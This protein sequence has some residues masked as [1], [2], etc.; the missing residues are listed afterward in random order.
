MVLALDHSDAPPPGQQEFAFETP[1]YQ[2]HCS[3]PL[4]I[5]EGTSQ[6]LVMAALPPGTRPT[7]A[8]NAMIVGRRVSSLRRP[9]PPTPILGRGER[10]CAP[11]HSAT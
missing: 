4:G 5:C 1:P 2:N 7:G 11:P 9:W 6:A 10:H 3:L 8:E